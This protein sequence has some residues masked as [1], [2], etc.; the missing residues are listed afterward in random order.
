MTEQKKLDALVGAVALGFQKATQSTAPKT[1][2]K[3]NPVGGTA[4]RD[5]IAEGVCKLI[6]LHNLFEQ[7]EIYGSH[8]YVH[9]VLTDGDDN[10]SKLSSFQLQNILHDLVDKIP[11]KRV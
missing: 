1:L 2:R 9:I 7:G 8:N 3:F 5:A 11:R 6:A 4:M 10:S